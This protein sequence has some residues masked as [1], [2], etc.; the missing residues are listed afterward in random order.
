M[1]KEAVEALEQ[2]SYVRGVQETEIWLADELAEVCRD[3]CKEV[4][5][6]V[7]NRAR[8]HAPPSGRALRTSSTP[9]TSTKFQL[10]SLLPLLLPYP[11]LS[12]LPPPNPFFLLLKSLKG[13]A[14]LVTKARRLRWPRARGLARMVL[15]LRIRARAKAKRSSPYQR[16]RVQRLLSS[17]RISFPSPRQLI[18]KMT[19]PEPKRSFRIPFFVPFLLLW[20]FFPVYNVPIF[21]SMKGY[22]FFLYGSL[23]S[24]QYLF[25]VGVVIILPFDET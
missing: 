16:P 17:S 11:P 20:H 3:Y 25:T 22:K 10:C 5:A 12:S 23:F 6:K 7:L 2:A 19:L 9:R 1:A 24:L 15:G 8:V 21:C 14:K 13:L 4:W 18:P